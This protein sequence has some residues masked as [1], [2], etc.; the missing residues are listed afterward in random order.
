MMLADRKDYEVAVPHTPSIAD[1]EKWTPGQTI[2]FCVAVC[3]AFWVGVA[4]IVRS[5]F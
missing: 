2:I 4:L 1:E 5:L 3:G